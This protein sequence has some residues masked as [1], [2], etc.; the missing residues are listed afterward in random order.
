MFRHKGK[1][2]TIVHNLK[3]ASLLSFV[4]GIVNVAGFLAVNRLTTNVTGHFA[5]F[6]DG[7]IEQDYAAA[8]IYL[9]FILSFLAGA[10]TSNMVMELIAIKNLKY[11]YTIPVLLETGILIFIGFSGPDTLLRDGDIIACVLLFSMGLHNALVTSVSNAVVRTTHLTGLFTDLGI[12]L[13]Q[14]FFYRKKEQRKKLRASIFLRTVIIGF[15]FMGSLAGGFGFFRW[16][17]HILFLA[18][19]CLIGGLMYDTLKYRV[20]V[21]RRRYLQH[22]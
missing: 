2:R 9:L 19:A 3:L 13:S 5:F 10:F 1:S 22:S 12:E 7:V 16:G 15:F 18:A 20:V 6:A 11:I 21:L 14:L 8:G 17:I 4:A